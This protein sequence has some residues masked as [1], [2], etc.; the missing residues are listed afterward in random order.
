MVKTYPRNRDRNYDTMEHLELIL[1]NLY[2]KGTPVIYAFAFSI[3][4]AVPL[5]LV[6]W[7]YGTLVSLLPFE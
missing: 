1:R 2:R 7:Q 5:N 3:V 6:Y 4:L